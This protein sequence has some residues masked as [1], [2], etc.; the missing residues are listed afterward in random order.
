MGT[1]FYAIFVSHF[2]YLTDL[3]NFADDNFALTWSKVK[4]NASILMPNN[5]II[6]TKWLKDWS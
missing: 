1:V 2:F 5:L 3:A 4:Y 6:I